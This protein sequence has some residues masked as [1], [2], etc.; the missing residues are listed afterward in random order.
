MLKNWHGYFLYRN[1]YSLWSSHVLYYFPEKILL[2]LSLPVKD[3]YTDI[4]IHFHCSGFSA[5][6]I[7][8]VLN[9]QHIGTLFH[10]DAYLW[11]SNSDISAQDMA[12]TAKECSRRLQV[13]KYRDIHSCNLNNLIMFLWNLYIEIWS[14]IYFSIRTYLQMRGEKYCWILLQH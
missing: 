1:N 5:D 6:N 4:S 11:V 13:N 9:G 12:I 10:K 14:S 2:V 8:K 7:T 3:W